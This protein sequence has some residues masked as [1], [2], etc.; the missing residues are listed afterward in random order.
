MYNLLKA[1]A[2]NNSFVR[3]GHKGDE[4]FSS[5]ETTD[6]SDLLTLAEWTAI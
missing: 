3:A 2:E 1:D 6:S 4:R 5:Q